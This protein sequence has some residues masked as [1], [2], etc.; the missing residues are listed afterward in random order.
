MPQRWIAPR[1][2]PPGTFVARRLLIPAH[3]DWLSIVNGALD[4]LCFP[5]SFE[6]TDGIS[7]EDTAA[8]FSE[9][10]VA[11]A[12]QDWAMIGAI[13]PYATASVPPN[14]L[15]CDGSSHNR[16]DYPALYAALDTAFIDDADT[17][18][19]PD[20]RGRSPTG[21]GTGTGLSARNM[22]DSGGSERVTL[23]L[24]EIPSHSHSYTPAVGSTVTIG[25][26]VPA[27]S[28]I[29]GIASTG[30]AGSDTSHD[31]LPPYAAIGFCIIAR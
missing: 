15:A 12:T 25:T 21:T 29:P 10:Y 22:G 2:S 27:P 19:T 31:N 9:M 26:G 7:P 23:V 18:H 14:C 28:A 24:S 30:N 1:Y 16:V 5:T 6:Q 3:A 17:F 11:Y 13:I 20:L 4:E 8:A